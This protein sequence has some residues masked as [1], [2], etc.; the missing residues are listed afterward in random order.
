MKRRGFMLVLGTGGAVIALT[1]CDTM[2]ASAGQ[3]WRGPPA[4][5]LDPQLHVLAWAM[6]APNPHNL[7]SWIADLREPGVIALHVDL[8]RLLPET[9][10]Q[11]RQILIG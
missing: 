9:D 10:R 1:G 5:E 2:P 8:T 3:P 7:Q 6:L 11:G 4:T